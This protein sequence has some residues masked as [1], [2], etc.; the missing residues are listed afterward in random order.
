M[1][2]IHARQIQLIKMRVRKT[3][4]VLYIVYNILSHHIAHTFLPQSFDFHHFTT[5]IYPSHYTPLSTLHYAKCHENPSS[6]A[7]LFHAETQTVG[8][9]GKRDEVSVI[10]P[11]LNFVTSP[12]NDPNF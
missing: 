1:T 3:K 12:K 7:E 9:V 5:H 2:T 4:K 6:E 11:F 8:Q 10:V